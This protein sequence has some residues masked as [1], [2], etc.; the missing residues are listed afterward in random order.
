MDTAAPVMVGIDGSKASVRAAQWAADEAVARDTTLRLVYVIDPEQVDDIEDA[1]V[2]AHHAI[3]RAWQTIVDSDKHVKLESEILQGNPIDELTKAARRASLIC[4]GHKGTDDSAPM[5]R[6]WTAT[7]LVRKAPTSVAVIRRRRTYRAGGLHRWVVALL[8]ESARSHA[9]LQ[10][11]LD[12]ATL[13]EAP[14]LALTTW[15]TVAN[16][17]FDTPESNDIRVEMD[18]YLE[19]S[20]DDSADVQVCAIPMSTDVSTLLEQ[21]ASIEQ[22]YVVDSTRHDLLEQL[23]GDEARK[24]MRRT[25]CSVLV[26]HTDPAVAP[27]IPEYEL[28]DD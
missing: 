24:A 10:T 20:Q 18:R 26:V 15:S 23:I 19:E 25:N 28:V 8:D 22:L 11:A 14:L 2:G 12:E 16:G 7:S 4:L 5:A 1:M 3:H 9:V 17:H 13:R 6:G 21:S 27:D